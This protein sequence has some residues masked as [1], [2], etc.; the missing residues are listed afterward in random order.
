M[1]TTML[2]SLAIEGTPIGGVSFHQI[3][4]EMPVLVSESV[5]DKP[6]S[7]WRPLDD[8]FDLD[9]DRCLSVTIQF[10]QDG[11]DNEVRVK[12]VTEMAEVSLKTWINRGQ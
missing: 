2:G 12:V 8:A 6:P 11:C 10:P 3:D 7:D 1:F 5:S 9:F 4:G